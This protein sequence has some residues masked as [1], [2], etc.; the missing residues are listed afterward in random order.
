MTVAGEKSILEA[1]VEVP[2]LWGCYLISFSPTSK[3]LT[4]IDTSQKKSHKT[5]KQFNLSTFHSKA[6]EGQGCPLGTK[7]AF[8]KRG[9][10]HGLPRR[11]TSWDR[12]NGKKSGTRKDQAIH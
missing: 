9:P 10:F 5:G 7:P 11:T 8:N 6:E 1:Q 4:R 12:F 3:R 2:G